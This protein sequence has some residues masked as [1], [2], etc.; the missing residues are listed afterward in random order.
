[1]VMDR[2]NQEQEVVIHFLVLPVQQT[3]ELLAVD[4]NPLPP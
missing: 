1:M 2:R 4:A 3:A